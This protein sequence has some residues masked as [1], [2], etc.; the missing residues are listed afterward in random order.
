M[1]P[2]NKG[3]TLPGWSVP[4]LGSGFF[5]PFTSPRI[6]QHTAA[7]TP[8]QTA[9]SIKFLFFFLYIVH[10]RLTEWA[11]SVAYFF[12]NYSLPYLQLSE[13]QRLF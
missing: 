6:K 8:M 11:T 7:I 4:D 13:W 9:S 2:N 3:R 1:P 5:K 12:V 10:L